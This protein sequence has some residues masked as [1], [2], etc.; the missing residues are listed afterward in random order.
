MPPE[1]EHPSASSE[2]PSPPE[3]EVSAASSPFPWFRLGVFVGTVFSA[4]GL[5]LAAWAWLFI[6]DDLAPLLSRQLTKSLERPVQL[7]DV[8]SVSL[9]SLRVGPSILGAAA[10]DTTTVT[11]ESVTVDFDLLETLFTQKLGL[12]LT[13]TGAQGY[14]E[15][16]ADRGWIN[17]DTPDWEDNERDRRFEISLDDIRVR[18]SQL[19]LV[20]LPP[21]EAEAIPIPID[22]VNGQVTFDQVIVEGEERRQTRFDISGEPEAGGELVV[23]GEV[24][25]LLEE[26]AINESI[27]SDLGE[28][29]SSPEDNTDESEDEPIGIKLAI[30]ADQAPLAD[31]LNFTLG[32]INSPTDQVAINSG[33]VSGTM[34]MDILP[35]EV[36]YTGAVSADDVDL[37]TAILPLPVENAQ[38]QARFKSN[39]WTI[40]RLSGDYGEITA[41]AEGIVDFE[42]GYDLTA[43]ANEVSVEEF[44]NT[45]DLELPVPVDG[46]FNAIAQ[47]TGDIASPNFSG[48]VAST[49]PLIVDKVTFNGAAGEFF[50]PTQGDRL[51][52]FL[53]NI[54]AT[55]STGGSL[56]GSGQ[57]SLGEGSP[58]SFNLAGRGL[59]A[60]QLANL[61]GIEPN[62]T[63]GTVAADAVVTGNSDRVSTT[64]A[65]DAPNAQYPGR[66]VVDIDGNV[67][68]FRDTVFQLGGGTVSGGGT[69]IGGLWESDV[70]LQ[71]VQLAA[72]SPDLSGTVSGQFQFSGSTENTSIDAIA[73]SGNVNFSDGL[74]AFSDQFASLDGPLIAQVAWNGEKIVVQQAN[75]D[76]I[77][78]SGTLTPS[79][80]RGFTGLE[81][82][83]LQV[84][85]QDFALAE[86]PF[87]T[88]EIISL[89]GR[90][91]FSGN[92]TGNPTA[93]N[94][95]G[96]VQLLNL[97][98]NSL[99]FNPLLTGSINY[100]TRNGLNLNVAGG[101]DK[102]ALAVG[103]TGQS[104]SPVALDLPAVNFDVQ[105][106]EAFA[107]GQTIGNL[108]NVQAGDF[109]LAALN[110]P[111][112]GAADIGQVRGTLTAAD[113]TV[114]LANQTLEG[115][116]DI[117]KLGIGYIN[118]GKLVGRVR[119]ADRV[120][121]FT[122][123]E[124]RLGNNL[125]TLTGRVGLNGLVPTYSANIQ[126][127]RGNIQNI[128]TALSIYRLEDFRRGLK[129]P[130]WL[131]DPLSQAELAAILSTSQTGEAN[132]PL[133]NQ[134]RRLSEIQALQAERAQEEA[135]QPLPPLRELRGPF[136][137]DIVLNGQGG[138][139]KLDF[140]LAGANWTWGEDYSAEEVIAIGSLTPNVLTLE[141]VRFASVIPVPADSAAPTSAAE[142]A[143]SRADEN[144]LDVA[145]NDA[146]TPAGAIA[147]EPTEAAVNL[148]GQLVFGSDTELTSDL[149]ATARNLNVAILTD[150]LELP[151]DLEGFADASATLGGT[152]SNPQ[153]RGIAGLTDA[154]INDTPIETADAQ[155]IYQNARLSLLSTL[156]ATTPDNP[157]SLS[158]QIPYA[159]NFM[160]VQPETNDINIDINVRDEGLSLL[161][162]FNKQVAWESGEGEIS[163]NVDGTLFD[164]QISGFANLS[165]AVLSAQ[166]LPEPLTNVNGQ[167]NFVGDRIIVESLQGRFSDGQLTAAGT[168]PLISP[169]ISG[170]QIGALEPPLPETEASP[171][172]NPLFPQPLAAD[173]PLTVNFEDVDL[174]LQDLYTGGVDGQIVVGGS[175][176][177]GGPQI[178]GQVV[179]SNGQVLLSN[180]QS[181]DSET[182]LISSLD[183]APPE[184][185]TSGITP[186]FRDLELTLSDDIRVVQGNLLNF[187]ADGTLT[188]NGP[189]S[190]L[191]PNGVINVR[192]GRVSLFTTLFRLRGRNNTATFTPE[193]GL[194]NPFLDVSLR[195]SVPEVEGAS[196]LSST[197][198][199]RADV[200]E[201]PETFFESSSSLRTIRVR[202][203]VNGPANALFDN[204]ELSSSPPR[205]QSELI[206]LV[207]GGFVTALESTVGS[208]SGGGDDFTGLINLVGGTLLTNVQDII[209][210]TLS[211]SEFR[212][213][214]V[215]AAS[216]SA[217]DEGDDTGIDIGAEIGFDI[218]DNAS[219]S[220]LKVLT[221]GTNPE[222][223]LNYRLTDS[224]SVRSTTNFDDINQVLLEY[225]VRF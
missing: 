115:D 201:T 148:A 144:D 1:P 30:Q 4:V 81:S 59:P 200:A 41:V 50:L 49:S 140:D 220:I 76:R 62:F 14:L 12:D 11:A 51:Q 15:Q 188:L 28:Q 106:R 168:F 54:A 171:A 43:V 215:T 212:L 25:P 194:Q 67:V 183:T 204:L 177:I 16:D 71:G 139:F 13:I 103:P 224:L 87:E 150:V 187:V 167:A 44:T 174:S 95:N 206:A 126:T 74:A 48:V 162:I 80:D 47:V 108:L 127:Q 213:F 96:N 94:F 18:D 92:L 63:L 53:S 122:D 56:L 161:N 129:P 82:F 143:D 27:S 40:D 69:L 35:D 93:P 100:S 111:A 55:P 72:F 73:A 29:E 123:G 105:W 152:L 79:F 193:M 209:G 10:D 97:V 68:A 221:D 70:D 182:E 86:L 120:A 141:P 217:T 119:Y 78:A 128:L 102:I 136:A 173:R 60:R 137:G 24:Q 57:V 166:I 208:L 165:D 42:Q 172:P 77:I 91:N 20:P 22:Q 121:T 195:A 109:P 178:G 190:D 75:L 118:V 124:L 21:P 218:T 84:D 6:Q 39:E 158:A 32:T 134:L 207:G 31:I 7:G 156:T 154:T 64:I 214:P 170:A 37:E 113:F 192:S 189:P 223:G 9:G 225:E 26:Q 210:S 33:V 159:F 98:V 142:T 66:G 90:T 180:G 151:I 149:Q 38:G 104:S 99:P 203:D 23:K 197:P 163:L 160:D 216:R 133:L 199:F 175:A 191:E 117:N 202:A 164:P 88:P 8:E 181:S 125:Y 89:V 58:F 132:A 52:L 131:Q 184:T 101:T 83:D 19:T 138:D 85:G 186:N 45:I 155:F 205:S 116:I 222:F 145:S 65:W 34:D 46:R 5:G 36:I 3:R 112:G 211:L 185:D 2:D 179:L 198:F 107:R 146:P 135:A 17:I 169:I 110:F 114:N 130:E 157:L 147:V 176:L 153:M 219:A 196:P 61:Y